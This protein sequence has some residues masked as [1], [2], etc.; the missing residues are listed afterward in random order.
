MASSGNN[1]GSGNFFM[2][3]GAKF[4]LTLN[5]KR[6]PKKK[7]ALAA[8]LAVFGTEEEVEDEGGD[9]GNFRGARE[10]AREQAANS[11]SNARVQVRQIPPQPS[12]LG[13]RSKP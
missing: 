4:G 13:A 11:V 10:L 5:P 6:A 12:A 2:G 8:P 1:G 7:P 3:T 9:G